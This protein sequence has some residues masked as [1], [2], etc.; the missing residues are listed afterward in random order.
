MIFKQVL[1]LITGPDSKALFEEIEKLLS[2][3]DLNTF[4]NLSYEIIRRGNN[5]LISK[6]TQ[7]LSELSVTDV[8][9][10]RLLVFASVSTDIAYPLVISALKKM[11]GNIEDHLFL[12]LLF[13]I[14]AKAPSLIEDRVFTELTSW[15][16]DGRLKNV[17]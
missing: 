4:Y 2:Y 16:D 11:R 6:L 15:I 7:K 5:E 10:F 13:E 17:N 1:I 12:D 3:S 14:K 8:K 9:S